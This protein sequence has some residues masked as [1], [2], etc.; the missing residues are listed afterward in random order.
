[1]TGPDGGSFRGVLPDPDPL[2]APYWNAATRHELVVQRCT[3]CG[4]LRFPPS[5]NCGRCASESA[6]W[7]TVIGTGTLFSYIW[8]YRSLVPGLDQ[9]IPYNVVL[10]GLDEDPTVRIMGNVVGVAHGDLSI[11]AR[12][13]VYFDDV[14]ADDTIPRWCLLPSGGTS[15]E[16][17][18]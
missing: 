2:T 3:E 12:V 17:T 13:Q 9:S 10:V 5:E 11:G 6:S 18:R 15:K 8:V 1:M 16:A 4:K 7:A 14:T